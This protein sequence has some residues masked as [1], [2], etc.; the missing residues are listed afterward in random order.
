MS[1]NT[2]PKDC[3]SCPKTNACNSAYGF[4]DCAYAEMINKKYS[5][6]NIFSKK[7]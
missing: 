3:T 4:Y 5:L 7:K 1:K 6:K 2:Y